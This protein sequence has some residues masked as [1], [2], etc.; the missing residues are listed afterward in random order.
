MKKGIFAVLSIVCAFLLYSFGMETSNNLLNS[1]DTIY[2][3]NDMYVTLPVDISTDEGDI[4]LAGTEVI[5]CPGEGV[6]CAGEFYP[7]E[8]GTIKFNSFKG[9]G[10]KNIKVITVK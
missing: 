9:E 5:F 7:L 3:E 2:F 10:E 8:G 6:K 4:M 1:D